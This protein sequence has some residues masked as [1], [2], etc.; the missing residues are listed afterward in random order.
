MTR[1]LKFLLPLWSTA[2]RDAEVLM[3]L[4]LALQR[5]GCE[6]VFCS[7]FDAEYNIA[8]TK[9]DA[10]VVM[11]PRGA[12]RN[13]E[14]AL[15]AKKAGLPVFS[16]V[17]EGNYNELLDQQLQSWYLRGNLGSQEYIAD[18][19]LEWSSRA[20]DLSY[21]YIRNAKS[22]CAVSGAIGFDRYVALKQPSEAA[23]RALGIPQQYKFV[24]TYAGWTF[25]YIETLE[26]GS[27][28]A[29]YYG[30]GFNIELLRRERN[31]IRAILS[32][33]PD[34]CPDVWFIYKEHPACKNSQ[35]SEIPTQL[36]AP[37]VQYMT[38][39]YPL[40][41][42]IDASNLWCAFE[43]T[44]FAEAWTAN[45]ET[46]TINPSCRDFTRNVLWKGSPL[47]ESAEELSVLIREKQREGTTNSFQELSTIRRELLQR[48]IQWK[49]GKNAIRAATIIL[50]YLHQK[51]SKASYANITPKSLVH[52][53]R[54]QFAEFLPGRFRK[55]WRRRKRSFSVQEL[56][57]KR[58]AYE[59]ILATFFE[60]NKLTQR[61][62]LELC[63]LHDG[64][65]GFRLI[66]LPI[67]V[68]TEN[69][70]NK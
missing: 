19:V 41:T 14:V 28:K 63:S 18:L 12:K 59:P 37:N 32:E 33:I 3:L 25:D 58:A 65:F 34:L 29:Q 67:Y 43:S 62:F 52:H 6:F 40:Q 49:D 61:E 10:V 22:V 48:T 44:T 4:G 56:N 60:C 70:I 13:I 11:D 15:F 38:N 20:R 42:M 54:L 30:E 36:R 1:K 24:V 35:F 53:M 27:K 66:G 17:A 9:P 45:I 50:S 21:D 26:K 51:E 31:L 47:V 7:M 55:E 8:T 5:A 69:P 64:V 2:G 16:P 39:Q 46:L 23:R 57:E 68:E